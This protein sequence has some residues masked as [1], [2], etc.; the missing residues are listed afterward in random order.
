MSKSQSAVV[1][2]A[3]VLE[4]FPNVQLVGGGPTSWGFYYDFQ[5]S[6]PFQPHFLTLIEDRMRHMVKHVAPVKTLEMVQTSAAE[7]LQ[8]QGQLIK[9][10]QAIMSP[11]PL[12]KLAQFGKFIDLCHFP[13]ILE[14]S[15]FKLLEAIGKDTIRIVGIACPTK[16]DLKAFTK[17]WT[18]MKGKT[19]QDLAQEL[20]FL[21]P[22]LEGWIWLS[23]GEEVRQRLLEV[24]KNFFL[25]QG[26]ELMATPS[27]T[28]IEMLKNH[29]K[30]GR[31][32][33]AISLVSCASGNEG[34]LTPGKGFV[35]QAY[36]FGS[37]SE[38]II[39]FLQFIVKFLKMFFFDFEVV[40][41]GKETKTLQKA[42]EECQLKTAVEREGEN[43]IEFRLRDVWGRPWTVP[44]IRSE[45]GVAIFSLFSS[46]ERFFALVLE[47]TKGALPFWLAPEQVRI[48]NLGEAGGAELL[49]T[50][51]REGW[52]ATLDARALPLKQRM[53]EALLERVPYSIVLGDREQGAGMVSVRAYG[54]EE[55]IQMKLETLISRLH[56]LENQ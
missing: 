24:W 46:M 44:Y 11:T 32:S 14:N 28:S 6:T 35:D 41:C 5:F 9:A 22:A 2:P 31:K 8:H 38:V 27:T 47:Q 39:S 25:S 29:A 56:E 49:S 13:V 26:F 21:A 20:N 40:L 52:R 50:L 48:L 16:D 10:K 34:M 54:S 42:L 33:A 4:L 7:L 18:G 55:S 3:A 51:K 45:R 43:G 19:H 37:A 17:S 53:R 1:L 36:Y 12:V 23:K 15:H 30:I